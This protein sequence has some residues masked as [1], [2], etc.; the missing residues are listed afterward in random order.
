MIFPTDFKWG[1]SASAYQTEGAAYADGRGE[2]IWT[3]FAHSAGNT[4]AGDTGDVATDHYHRYKDDIGI[5]QQLGLDAYRLSISWP[6]ILPAGVGRVNAAG[7]DWYDRLIDTLLEAKITPFA[8]LYHWDLPQALAYRGGWQNPDVVNWF[9]EYTDVV[10]RRLGDRVK[11]WATMNEPWVFSQLGYGT[12]EFAP[13]MRDLAAAYVVAHHALLAHA[14]SARVLRT[15]VPHAEIGILV[16]QPAFIAAS[17]KDEAAVALQK[18]I[19]NHWYLDPLFFGEYPAEAVAHLG[20][21]LRDVDLSQA[22]E[23]TVPLDYIGLNYYFRTLVGKGKALPTTA[24][25]W[26]IYPQGLAQLLRDLHTR[27]DAP[28]LY[29]TENGAAFADP[30]P[31]KE[32]V[33]DPKREDYLR[34]HIK[35]VAEVVAEGLPVKGYFVWSLLDNFE[36][37]LGYSKR[38]GLTYVDYKTQRRTIKDSGLWYRDFI[39]KSRDP[40]QQA[41]LWA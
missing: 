5:M 1:I 40:E 31:W 7:L 24:M 8:N 29:V 3:R 11:W 33:P 10:A 23:M 22:A 32:R 26:E 28:T 19:R 4:H 2:C 12:G 21:T 30:A 14:M 35:A 36:W 15:V 18:A 20:K 25:G 39:T 38:F 13:G 6:R 16:D 27:Y 41:S 34:D 9:G 17:P 37:A